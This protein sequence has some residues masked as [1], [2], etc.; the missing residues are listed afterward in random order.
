MFATDERRWRAISGGGTNRAVARFAAGFVTASALWGA[1]AALYYFVLLEPEPAV[2]AIAVREI[3]AEIEPVESEPRSRRS[4]RR[5]GAMT[6]RPRG[7]STTG[8]DIDSIDPVS[9]DLG[10]EGG[11]A[12]LPSSAIEA[13]MDG[14]M[15]SIRRCFFLAASDEPVTGRLVFGLRIE[16]TGRVGGVN[17]SGPSALT[18]GEA[19]ECLRGAARGATFP[20]FDGPPMVARYPIVLQ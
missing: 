1:G 17:L 14:V 8:D 12:Q 6:E 20:S 11:E 13:G 19:G 16:P 4:R 15:G 10:S 5:A 9:L 2:E 3:E 7:E 18:T